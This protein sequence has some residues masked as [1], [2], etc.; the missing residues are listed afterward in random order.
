MLFAIRL[1]VIH[2]AK[3]VS[4]GPEHSLLEWVP[5]PAIHPPEDR[6]EIGPLPSPS[7]CGPFSARTAS[8]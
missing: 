7:A 3:N 6:I 4:I 2:V 1:S 8:A 5:E